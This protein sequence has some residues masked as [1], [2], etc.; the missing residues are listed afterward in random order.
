[1]R[2]GSYNGDDDARQKCQALCLKNSRCTGVDIGVLRDH[3]N[4]CY[5]NYGNPNVTNPTKEWRHSKKLNKAG[6]NYPN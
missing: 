4:E 2:L 1:M 3:H 5:L 6:C